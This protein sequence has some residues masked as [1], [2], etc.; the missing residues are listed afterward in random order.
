M[1][2]STDAAVQARKS[3][4]T[5]W[6]A[7]APAGPALSALAGD[8]EADVLVIGGGIAGL[9]TA[10]HLAEAG[11][12]VLLVEAGQPGDGATGQS[13]GLVAPD[14]IR[15][16]PASIGQ[17]L[18]R[19]TGELMTRFIGESAQRCFDLIARHAIDCDARQDGFYAPVHTD[20]LAIDQRAA[21]EQWQARGFDVTAI[22]GAETQARLGTKGY[23]GALRFGQGGWL[24]PLAYA[25]GL[26]RAAAA[27]GARLRVE[28]PVDTL[29]HVDG[30]WR[31]CTAGGQIYARRVVLAANGGN[32]RLHPA[33]RHAAVP[34]HVVE[35]A[36]APLPPELRA[37]VLPEGG[38]FTDKSPYVFSARYDSA[39]RLISA[40]PQSFLV[41]G[42]QA[43][44]NEAKRRLARYFKGSEA[45]EIESIWEGV[46]WVNGSL[47]PEIHDLGHGAI[48]V[49][50]CNGRGISINSAIGV[51]LA[52][53]LAADDLGKLSIQPRRPRP[54]PFYRAAAQLPKAM[55]TLAYLSD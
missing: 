16:T 10:L 3:S 13:G 53:A 17:T 28:T 40:F 49:Q 34:L 27:A 19:D 9:S 50:A 44:Q 47:L 33:M 31:A 43:F 48:A 12:D 8:A 24:N 39:G 42:A 54:F 30:R 21:A 5:L 35:F 15:H 25:R 1:P 32:A 11:V 38:A 41:R 7:T 37:Q 4:A 45:V 6:Q 51:E 14:Y 22:D 2:A 46:A 36:T 23:S 52:Q 20:R 29:E 55:M 18:G 26:A